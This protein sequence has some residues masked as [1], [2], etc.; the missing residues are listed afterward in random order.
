[1][2]ISRSVAKKLN[3]N[4]NHIEHQ[5]LYEKLIQLENKKSRDKPEK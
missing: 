2:N 4:H 1:M 5:D 3:G